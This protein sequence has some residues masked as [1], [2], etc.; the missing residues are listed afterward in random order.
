METFATKE[1]YVERFGNV[2][3]DSALNACLE[4]ASAAIRG[5]LGR[6]GIDYENPDDDLADRMMRVCRSVANRLLSSSTDV[7]A[8]TTSMMTVVGPFTKQA[9]FNTSFGLPKLLPSELSM[10]GIGQ[11]RIG[12]A[13]M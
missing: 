12:W 1:Q 3:D 13:R 6:R 4:D 8:G 11:G 5:A 9:S 2:D 10:L 7:P